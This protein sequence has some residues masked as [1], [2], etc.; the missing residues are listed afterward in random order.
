MRGGLNGRKGGNTI[1]M[2]DE[3]IAGAELGQELVELL[4]SGKKVPYPFNSRV[5]HT[6]KLESV[7]KEEEATDGTVSVQEA[8]T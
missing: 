2:G 3:S 4:S 7:I 1:N 8:K 5:I 6:N